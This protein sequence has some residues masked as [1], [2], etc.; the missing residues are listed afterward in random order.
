MQH[1]SPP[2]PAAAEAMGSSFSDCRDTC[3]EECDRERKC[4]VDQNEVKISAYDQT[5]YPQG[6][7]INSSLGR[8]HSLVADL[9]AAA[10]MPGTSS[11]S[12]A[13]TSSRDGRQRLKPQSV[14]WADGLFRQTGGLLGRFQ[15]TPKASSFA[16]GG[17]STGRGRGGGTLTFEQ[18]MS[19]ARGQ[20]SS[21][22]DRGLYPR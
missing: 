14:T 17:N 9:A 13:A 6:T 5:S 3:D 12:T 18:Q 20:P 21:G 4:Y 11:R 1:P 19:I 22:R 2:P 16:G 7:K 10:G 15:L 8:Q